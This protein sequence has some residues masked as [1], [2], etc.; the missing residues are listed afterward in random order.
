[1]I[2]IID[3][4]MVRGFFKSYLVCLASLLSLYIVVDLFT[5][6]DD[7][8]HHKEKAGL[9]P[10]VQHI[11]SYYGYKSVQIFDRLCE[12]IV[13]LAAMFT[14]A[15]MQRN[16]EQV[17]LLSAGVSTRR[18]VAPVLLCAFAM[19]SLAGLSQE[20]L[21]PRIA[22]KL[23]LDRDDPEGEKSL[24]VHGA[25]EPNG[26]HLA[27]EKA[28]RKGQT[29]EKL[30]CTIP[31]SLIRN[32]MH[33]QADKATYVKGTGPRQ[34]GWELTL[35]QVTGM[36]PG[37]QVEPIPGVLEVIDDGHFFLYTREVDFEALTRKADWFQFASTWRIFQDLLRPGAARSPSMAVLFQMRLTRPL[38]GM[39][40][41]LMGL[42]VILR[43]QNRNV[44]ISS[45][46]C[47]VLCALF[48]AF[49]YACKLMGDNEF[50]SPA[51]AAWLPVVSFGPFAIVLFDAV[52]T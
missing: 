7:F 22:E 6:L 51:L 16:N 29:V 10:V 34:G 41:V 35:T 27:G 14:V 40:L 39:V 5:N 23:V 1:M 28:V 31:E 46:Q 21:I 13:L 2:K 24:L 20:V 4:Q 32:Q 50:V 48:F 52:H 43:D 33:L 47:L 26:I 36:P 37:E 49:N 44:I 8:I 38:V 12:A 45:G 19:L 3:R 17:P 25:Y 30:A 9:A 15:W 42:S 18:I 11:T